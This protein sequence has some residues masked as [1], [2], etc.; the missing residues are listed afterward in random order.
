MSAADA[1]PALVDRLRHR[2]GLEIAA[3]GPG[4]DTVWTA[5]AT[6]WA[7]LEPL[8]LGEREAAGHLTGVATHRIALR[9]RAGLDSRHRFVKGSRRFRIL[10]VRDPDETGRHLVCLVEETDR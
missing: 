10:A 1:E 5:V 3:T 6:V 8:G 9:R 4:G 7:A 2:L